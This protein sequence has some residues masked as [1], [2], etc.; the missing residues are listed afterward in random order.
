MVL[1]TLINIS[2]DI[3]A[4]VSWWIVKNTL[5]GTYYLVSYIRPPAKTK[6]EIELIELRKELSMLNKKLHM[7]NNNTNIITRHNYMI[8]NNEENIL[9]DT[10]D[11]QILDDDFIFINNQTSL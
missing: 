10:V 9:N 11:L 8:M 3:S 7:I 2:L 5:Y 6:E 4:S 1:F